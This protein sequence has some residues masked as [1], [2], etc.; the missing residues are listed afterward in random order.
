MGE[1]TAV[2]AVY[3]TLRRGQRNHPLLTGAAFLGTGYVHGAL[4]DVPR[5][6][7]RSY[8]YPALVASSAGRV[9]VEVYRLATEDMLRALDV[10]EHYDSSDEDASQYVRRVVP[11]L[12]GPVNEAY[13]YLYAGPPDELGRSIESGDWVAYTARAISG[14]SSV[15][16]D[17]R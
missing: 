10:L 17:A 2:V 8:A 6:P 16:R 9:A 4:Y 15:A 14:P 5:T 7:Y 12:E 3:G 11:V 1:H 13:A